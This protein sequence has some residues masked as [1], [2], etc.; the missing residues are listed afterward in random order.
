MHPSRFKRFIN[1]GVSGFATSRRTLVELEQSTSTSSCLDRLP[2]TMFLLDAVRSRAWQPPLFRMQSRQRTPHVCRLLETHALHALHPAHHDRAA[3]RRRYERRTNFW[4]LPKSQKQGGLLSSTSGHQEKS[5]PY[6][7][8]RGKCTPCGLSKTTEAVYSH[9]HYPHTTPPR[10]AS[11]GFQRSSVGAKH[12]TPTF[13]FSDPFATNF[14]S[15]LSTALNHR[16]FYKRRATGR[17]RV[18][19]VRPTPPYASRLQ[20]PKLSLSRRSTRSG[21]RTGGLPHVSLTATPRKR[22]RPHGYARIS[23]QLH[24]DRAARPPPVREYAQCNTHDSWFSDPDAQPIAF[25]LPNHPRS[26]ARSRERGMQLDQA[27]PLFTYRSCTQ[28]LRPTDRE[29]NLPGHSIYSATRRAHRAP[30]H[31]L[32]IL[33]ARHAHHTRRDKLYT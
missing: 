18:P 30:I 10:E 14:H 20:S 32:N 24:H 16:C 1:Q 27:E 28:L 5:S 12:K 7:R 33:P 29:R 15:I 13:F 21:K 4:S 22:S 2:P 19:S 17:G 11:T 31:L 6:H 8:E 26:P 3:A 25:E 9:A 23:I